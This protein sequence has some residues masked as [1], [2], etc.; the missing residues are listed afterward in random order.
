MLNRS[1]SLLNSIGCTA[2]ASALLAVPAYAQEVDAAEERAGNVIIVTARK[3]EESLLEVPVAITTFDAE[4][5]ESR[6]LISISDLPAFTPGFT[7]ESFAT[8][9]GR[10]DNSPRFRGVG[11]NTGSPTR[12][13]ASVFID[14]IFVANG[15]QGVTLSDV[16]RVEI[17]KGPQ[18]AFFGRNTFGGAINYITKTPGND[19]GVDYSLTA[20]TR[21]LYD[22]SLG[23]NLPVSDS[24]KLRLNGSYRDKGGHYTNSVN[25]DEVG[26]EKTW[27]IGGTAYFEPSD[28]FDAKI[29][30]NYFENEDGTPAVGFVDSSY[31]NCGPFTVGGVTGTDRT[32]CGAVPTNQPGANTDLSATVLDFYQNTLIQLNGS[33]RDSLGLDRKSLRTSLQFNVRFPD[34]S[35]ELSW[36]TG[37]NYDEVNLF[38]DGDSTGDNQFLS[39]AGRQ[40][41]DF[42]QEIRFSGQSFG[43]FLDWQ[44]GANFFDQRFTNNGDYIVPSLSGG[45]FAFSAGEPAEEQVQTLGFF[46]S[47]D[48]NLTDKLTISGEARYQVDTVR[49][50]DDITAGASFSKGK[51]TSFLPRVIVNYQ[52]TPDTLFYASFSEGNL[53]GGFNGSVAALTSTELVRLDAIQPGV[54]STFD[55]ESLRN[56][57]IGFKHNF[58]GRGFVS[59]AGFYM[60][61]GNQAVRRSDRI[62]LDSQVGTA[63]TTQ[64]SYFFNVGES[65]I[66]G[67]EFEGSY[68][69]VDG[70]TLSATAAYIDS[71]LTSFDNSGI[72]GEVFGS[73]DASG[74]RS[75]RF[76]KF[77]GSLS[78]QYTGDIN[79]D[80]GF[81]MRAD[82]LY[83][84]DRL[85]SEINLT[86]ADGGFQANLRAG[87]KSEKVRIEAFVTNVTNDDTPTAVNRFRDLSAQTPLFDFSTFG[88]MVGL[89]DKRQFGLRISGN[90]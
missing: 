42:S 82:G 44:V 78:A 1:K 15:A 69:L 64:L 84:G 62:A 13:T 67:V 35:V 22:A 5:I 85:A 89:R 59:V 77:S 73:T 9:P 43:D 48:I 29:R 23:I 79:D 72:Y 38:L 31:H 46:G 56:Y 33:P 4:A 63:N 71:V 76:P 58:G 51:F 10:F 75:E 65:E 28:N 12:Q 87:V 74:T 27:S 81:F 37:L 11:V 18:S 19:F 60:E 61:R 55:E 26:R 88:W 36:L 68:E 83:A 47:A 6:G 66:K 20:A 52:A 54:G 24:L 39:Y 21:G 90:F 16:E 32:L 2:L 49:E 3:S 80:W 40:F 41:R 34:S 70:F 14:G 86:R 30:V 50:D 25:G 17:I 8:L 45:R 57:E 53:P 7:Y